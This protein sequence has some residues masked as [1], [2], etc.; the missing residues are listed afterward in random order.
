MR[1]R[2]QSGAEELEFQIAPMIDVLLTVLVFFIMI[3]SAS[4]LQGD[5]NIKLPVAA[6]ASKPEKS[7]A[8]AVLN[9]HWN[10]AAKT[11]WVV[12]DSIRYEKLDALTAKLKIAATNQKNFRVLIRADKSLPALY[13][14]R[15][16]EACA[17]AG[18]SDTVF[19]AVNHD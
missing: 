9:L 19:T 4:V 18:I 6:N 11:G 16:L 10:P 17:E 15:V 13:V 1:C 2:H 14:Q 7:R 5:P 8:E 3:T 12:V